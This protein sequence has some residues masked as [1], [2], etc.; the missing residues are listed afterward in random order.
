MLSATAASY[1][2]LVRMGGE[3]EGG[4]GVGE[5]RGVWEIQ[6]GH[7]GEVARH[8]VTDGVFSI[9]TCQTSN[10]W[11]KLKAAN[12]N[13]KGSNV[14]TQRQHVMICSFQ[15]K[16]SNV[17]SAAVYEK[18]AALEKKTNQ[19]GAAAFMFKAANSSGCLTSMDNCLQAKGAWGKAAAFMQKAGRLVGS[20]CLLHCDHNFCSNTRPQA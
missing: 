12:W 17:Q 11:Q 9:I 1:S 13:M 7:V 14:R 19:N 4:G 2:I 16:G 6:K 15:A 10:D 3:R 5:G 8:S 20:C 18:T